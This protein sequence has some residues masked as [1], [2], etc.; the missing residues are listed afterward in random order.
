MDLLRESFSDAAADQATGICN[1]PPPTGCGAVFKLR[2]E[3][4]FRLTVDELSFPRPQPPYTVRFIFEKAIRDRSS[5][6]V[7]ESKN[8]DMSKERPV[9]PDAAVAAPDVELFIESKLIRRGAH[10]CDYRNK[11][12]VIKVVQIKHDRTLNAIG[13]A[14]FTALLSLFSSVCSFDFVFATWV[15]RSPVHPS[16][17]LS[18][19]GRAAQRWFES[20]C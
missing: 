1:E 19:C 12:A 15:C 17:L 2:D 13:K 6:I 7:P 8:A 4:F 20:T 18:G 5:G 14:K 11:V 10:G 9:R 3:V 16:S